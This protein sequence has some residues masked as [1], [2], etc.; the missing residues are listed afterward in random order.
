MYH[1]LETKVSKHKKCCKIKVN[2]STNFAITGK[3]NQI[4]ISKY[5]GTFMNNF[6]PNFSTLNVKTEPNVAF[7][8][9]IT[10]CRVYQ[11]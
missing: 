2:Y 11:I 6:H 3:S 10:I 1:I 7:F 8:S 5:F 9:K 4:I